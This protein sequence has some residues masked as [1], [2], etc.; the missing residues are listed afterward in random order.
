MYRRMKLRLSISVFAIVAFNAVS[1]QE[2]FPL[3]NDSIPN[4]VGSLS[5]DEKPTL[6][7][8]HPVKEKATGNAIIIFP[9][10]AYRFLATGME[11]TPIAKAFIEKGFVAFVVKYRLPADS[12]MQDKSMGPL[13]DAQQAIKY[14]RD[15]AKEYNIDSNK[16]GI[17]GYSA[18]GHL[19]STLGTHYDPAYIPNKEKTNLRPDFMILVYAVIS[20]DS[21]VTHHASKNF[22]LGKNA[23]M[24]K[25]NFFSNEKQ[26]TKETPP[27]YLTHAG[28]DWLV[29]V[30]NSI[31][32]YEALQEKGVSAEL[33]LFPKGSHGFI[34][35]LP[36]DEWMGPL[37][38]FLKK[39]GMYKEIQQ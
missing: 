13:M 4:S 31:V 25:S 34:L 37:L 19:A 12:A 27:T 24:E 18:G 11:G 7:V 23:S 21:S 32:M 10:G 22:L 39:Q 9:G 15:H 33:H 29:K 8:Y 20:M 2:V 1:A 17:I 26:V 35:G 5:N 16:I 30:K 28:D 3:Y 6:T 14:V 36:V 38:L